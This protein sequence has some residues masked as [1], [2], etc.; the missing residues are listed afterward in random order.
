MAPP[1]KEVV[2]ASLPLEEEGKGM[3]PLVNEAVLTASRLEVEG[4]G[5]YI[6]LE[7]EKVEEGTS[8][9]E[10]EIWHDKEPNKIWPDEE[11]IKLLK[12][13]KGSL[14]LGANMTYGGEIRVVFE[15]PSNFAIFRFDGVK[16]YRHRPDT[17]RAIQSH[18]YRGNQN[19]T[20]RTGAWIDGPP[21]SATTRHKASH[22]APSSSCRAIGRRPLRQTSSSPSS[23]TTT[24]LQL[25]QA[26]SRTTKLA[27]STP[28]R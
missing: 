3:A 28:S 14:G 24:A 9:L 2:L 4:K 23:C 7:K 19:L 8:D 18:L 17:I 16:L 5:N 10:D 27:I 26:F 6:E 1:V 20:N 15:T 21:T 25:F 13:K 22:R 12:N 11:P